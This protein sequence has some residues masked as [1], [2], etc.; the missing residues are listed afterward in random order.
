MFPKPLKLDNTKRGTIYFSFA[1]LKDYL[2]AITMR[3]IK[4]SVD[5]HKI[6]GK[7]FEL[8]ILQNCKLSVMWIED[9]KLPALINYKYEV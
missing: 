7:K 1:R 4:H 8:Q 5:I 6:R 9:K 2:R 3:I